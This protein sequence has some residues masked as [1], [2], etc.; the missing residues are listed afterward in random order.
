MANGT[1]SSRLI[2]RASHE[3]A[4]GQ[5]RAAADRA[6]NPVRGRS[7]SHKKNIPPKNALYMKK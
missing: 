3:M 2:A 4:C 7:T 1:N 6:I 5:N